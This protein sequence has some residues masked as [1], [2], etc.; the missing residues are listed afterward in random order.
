[1]RGS[2]VA[3]RSRPR[4][5]PPTSVAPDIGPDLRGPAHLVRPA[6]L[7]S[8]TVHHLPW[9]RADLLRWAVPTAV[10]AVLCIVAWAISSG[11]ARE[12]DQAGPLFLAIVALMVS[13]ISHALWLLRGRRAVGER[14][15]ELCT[16]ARLLRPRDRVAPPAA[17]LQGAVAVLV[18]PGASFIHRFECTFVA[19]RPVRHTS[20]AEATE[21]GMMPCG[22]CK[23]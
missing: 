11:Q 10:G 20:K 23:P 22:V 8:A 16:E 14:Q 6:D 13:G 19:N 17:I 12:S 7:A 1:M 2:S 18:T 15:R 4:Q 5:A 3:A 21:S 9:N